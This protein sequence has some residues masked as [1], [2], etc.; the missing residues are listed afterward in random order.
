M[1]TALVRHDGVEEMQSQDPRP[2]KRRRLTEEHVAPLA[3]KPPGTLTPPASDSD[4][5]ITD[6]PTTTAARP[7]SADPTPL[8]ARALHVLAT[9]A[10]AL[11][12]IRTLYQTHPAAQ[13]GL[14]DAV[15]ALLHAHRHGGKLL[16]CG[17]GKSGYIAQKL[18]LHG[19]LGDVRAPD[20]LLFVTFS[21]RTAELVTLLPHVPAATRILALSGHVRKEDCA[22]LVGRD[23]SILL[24]APIPEKE[25]ALCAGAALREVFGRNHPGGA[26]G[27]GYR[28]EGEG[29]KGEGVGCAVLELPS[30]SISGS[31]GG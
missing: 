23:D 20:V 1:A 31:D 24:P 11:A 18:A 27:V 5:D 17:V 25:E 6:D 29:M 19:D 21:G 8:L 14:H 12:H 13:S 26:I 28:R 3:Q 30:P 22:V 9:E 15:A 7:H 2:S 16:A 10:A 4:S